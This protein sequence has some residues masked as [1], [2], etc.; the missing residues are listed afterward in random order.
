MNHRLAAAV[1][2]ALA[3]ALLCNSCATLEE[4]RKRRA[5]EQAAGEKQRAKERK[6]AEEQRMR[7]QGYVF[8]PNHDPARVYR[9]VYDRV[10][11]GS[12]RVRISLSEQRAYLLTGDEVAI[13]TPVVTGKPSTPTPPGS[14]TIIEKDLDH[15]SNLYGD[16]VDAEGNVVKANVGVRTHKKPAGTKFLGAPMSYFMR[17]TS[18]GVGM[19]VGYLPGYAASHGCIRLPQ[20]IGPLIW[21]KVKLG[22]PVRIVP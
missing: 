6:E 19:H 20:D 17:L 18:G 2:S 5:E 12:A 15:R 11:P 10:T 22:T 1:S 8:V 3:L 16:Y 14:F 13:E 4:R 21:E 7:E 9:E